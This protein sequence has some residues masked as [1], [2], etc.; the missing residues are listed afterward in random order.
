MIE[1]KNGTY[2][3]GYTRDL[4]ARFDLHQTGRGAEYLRGRGPLKLVF[5]K[6]YRN[7][8]NAVVAEQ[9]LKKMTR[10][11]KKEFVKIFEANLDAGAPMLRFSGYLR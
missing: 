11:R 3:S 6:Q 4:E 1:D 10:K 7:F 9:R 2:Y 5:C 8:K